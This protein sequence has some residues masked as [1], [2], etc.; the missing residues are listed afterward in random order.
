M[1]ILIWYFFTGE[2]IPPKATLIFEVEL[3]DV[4]DGPKPE[5]IFKKIDTDE[6][7]KLSREEVLPLLILIVLTVMVHRSM[8]NMVE[9]FTN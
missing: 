9:W 4:Q 3:L 1:F 7:N 5:N 2:K 6:D 8:G